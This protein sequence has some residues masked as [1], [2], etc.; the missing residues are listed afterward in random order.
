MNRDERREEGREK[1]L[2][3]GE[4]GLVKPNRDL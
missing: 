2:V 1:R 4:D 3:E